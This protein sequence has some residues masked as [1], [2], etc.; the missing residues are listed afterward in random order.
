MG[1][2][3]PIVKLFMGLFVGI[4]KRLR[5]ERERLGLNQSDFG[6]AGGVGRK[7]QFNYEEAERSPD[8]AYLAAIATAGVDVQY[9]ITGQRR[10]DGI[11]EAAVHQAVLD[12]VD[13]L[14][15][16]KKL[17]AQQL[18]RA[19]VKLCARGG[20]GS[21]PQP[22][23]NFEGSIQEFHGAVGDVAGRDIIKTKGKRPL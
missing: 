3:V 16:D 6:A 22:P 23:K 1:T 9:V 8:A 10:G 18:A 21:S 20:A 17:D 15:L 12:A 5:E 14:S 19:V 7:T 13:L 11:G 4:G 2:F